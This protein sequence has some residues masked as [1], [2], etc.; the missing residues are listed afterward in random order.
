MECEVEIPEGVEVN[1][2]GNVISV[3]GKLGQLQ[4]EFNLD[5][6]KTE[7]KDSKLVL[8]MEKPRSKERAYLGTITAHLKNMIRGVTEGYVYKL[9]II[10]AHFPINASVEG[11]RVV[12]KNFAGEKKPRFAN[13]VGDTKV[14]IEGQNVSVE[15]INREEV[16]QTAANIE[17]ATRIKRKDPRVFSDGIYI[18]SK[19]E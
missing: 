16:G 6:I 15:G 8:S 3:K 4:R 13:I 18:V 14:K 19:G 9:K 12:I 17:Q 1:I 7:K 2:S 11:N 10:F 5:R